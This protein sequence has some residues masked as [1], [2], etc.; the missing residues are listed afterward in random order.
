MAYCKAGLRNAL[1]QLQKHARGSRL[2]WKRVQEAIL[3]KGTEY[4]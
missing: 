2:D 1:L 3:A 4:S